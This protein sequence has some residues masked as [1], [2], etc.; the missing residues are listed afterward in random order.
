M[1]ALVLNLTVTNMT[2]SRL[3]SDQYTTDRRELLKHFYPFAYTHH[4][5]ETIT[6]RLLN[7]DKFVNDYYTFAC[8]YGCK[9][10]GACI[11]QYPEAISDENP[12]GQAY[13][14]YDENA[15]A[16][17]ERYESCHRDGY[18]GLTDYGDGSYS[19]RNVQKSDGIIDSL[20]LIT[21][22]PVTYAA[23]YE[24]CVARGDCIDI[25]FE[26][27]GND[28][29]TFDYQIPQS[30]QIGNILIESVCNSQCYTYACPSGQGI[31]IPDNCGT[32]RDGWKFAAVYDPY[33]CK[34]ATAYTSCEKSPNHDNPNNTLYAI[35]GIAGSIAFVVIITLITVYI[36]RKCC[37]K[38]KSESA[39]LESQSQSAV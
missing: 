9:T 14:S 24:S 5:D 33:V 21:K 13:F 35:L 26:G 36:S 32:I 16:I 27:N 20:K 19:W 18:F 17:N 25:P 23:L 8:D 11:G 4:L 37:C 3:L 39:E 31:C 1:M 38:S 29:S 34:V 2:V 30:E 6:N 15:C 22:M 28:F 7:N 10:F 12:T